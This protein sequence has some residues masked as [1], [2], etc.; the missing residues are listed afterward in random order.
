[1]HTTDQILSD[2]LMHQFAERAAVYD[3]ENRFFHEDFDDL[4]RAGYLTIPVPRELGGPGL[5]LAE[6][7]REQRSLAI[8]R[9]L[10]RSASTCTSTGSGSPPICGVRATA[11]SNGC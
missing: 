11:R 7:C 5:T 3:R 9:P 4:R 6:M 2:K 8:M 1:M 10:R